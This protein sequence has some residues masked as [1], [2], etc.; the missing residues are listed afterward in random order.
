M[1][2]KSWFANIYPEPICLFAFIIL[3]HNMCY[4]QGQKL[5]DTA[6]TIARATKLSKF[7]YESFYVFTKFCNSTWLFHFSLFC[8]NEC[9]RTS[10]SCAISTENEAFH[11]LWFFST[12]RGIKIMEPLRVSFDYR[13]SSTNSIR[14]LDRLKPYTPVD[15]SASLGL[16]GFSSW[17]SLTNQKIGLGKKWK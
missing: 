15:I 5:K 1:L 10:F 6:T 9:L 8:K 11:W 12:R 17:A 16:M 4:W 2:L 14:C 13:F 3:R 7:L